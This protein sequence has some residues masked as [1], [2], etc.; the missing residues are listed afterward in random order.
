MPGPTEDRLIILDFRTADGEHHT[1]A[2]IV[3]PSGELV[4]E[5]YD[6]GKSVKKFLG[7]FDYEYWRPVKAEDVP[8][9]PLHPIKDRFEKESDFVAWLKDKGI[10]SEFAS[11]A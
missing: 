8:E 9:V 10:P 2:A 5:G 7:D 6:I 11:Y 1:L 4:L 3:K